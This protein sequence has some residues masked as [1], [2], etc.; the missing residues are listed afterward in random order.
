MTDPKSKKSVAGESGNGFFCAHII[1]ASCHYQVP[2]SFGPIIPRIITGRII[3]EMILVFMIIWF[4][5]CYGGGA[6]N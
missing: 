4:F 6:G 3:M 5:A 2:G 1:K